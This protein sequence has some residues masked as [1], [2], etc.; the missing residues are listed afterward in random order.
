MMNE[1]NNEQ[2]ILLEMY[3]TID[4]QD[5]RTMERFIFWAETED[6]EEW[7]EVLKD[8]KRYAEVEEHVEKNAQ[9]KEFIEKEKEEEQ[10]KK[11]KKVTYPDKRK[12]KGLNRE[13]LRWEG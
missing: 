8:D 13:R 6:K 5:I 4:N 1:K 3:S 2:D 12:G 11:V 7:L 10:E 9:R